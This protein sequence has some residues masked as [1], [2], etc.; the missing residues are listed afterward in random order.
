DRRSDA[1]V[2]A[3]NPRRDAGGAAAAQIDG[4]HVRGR[5]DLRARCVR[6]REIRAQRRLLRAAPA[7]ER[8]WAAVAATFDV[9]RDRLWLQSEAARAPLER[10]I[11]AV[12][13]ALVGIHVDPCGDGVVVR[14]EIVDPC[15][16]PFLLD[17]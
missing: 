7:A 10:G 16:A 9:A 5:V 13:L 17:R 1:K 8:A 2:P 11:R 6:V 4:P 14:R 15:G 3:L 12:A